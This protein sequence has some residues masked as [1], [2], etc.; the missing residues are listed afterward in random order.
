MRSSFWPVVIAPLVAGLYYL[1][2][3]LA[4]AESISAV[5]GRTDFFEI[6]R[7]GSHWIFR[8]IAEAIAI[9]FGTFVAASLAKGRVR[10]TATV[11]GLSI[12]AGFLLKLGLVFWG[13]YSDPVSEPWYQYVIDALAILAAPLIGIYVCEPVEDLHRQEPKG[14]G[15]INGFHLLW[16]WIPAYFY[17]LGLITPMSRMYM[18]DQNF[19]A[20]TI[21]LI[22]NAI[23]AA[24][25]AIPG[26]YGLAFLAGHHGNTMH[27]AG[28]NMVG[29]LV[30]IFGFVVG[31]A[32]Q[33]VWYLL[34][35]KIYFAIL[36]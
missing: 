31:I 12:S 11:S 35:Q 27:P 13:S 3:K 2:V 33:S 18:V 6:P 4:F 22:I 7:W 14:V 15:G 26:Y 8:I 20:M 32:I 25:I 23:P 17:A 9:G 5:M 21:A 19:I 16:L 29:A 28:R 24:A 34:F 36:G 30:L 10:L 1:A